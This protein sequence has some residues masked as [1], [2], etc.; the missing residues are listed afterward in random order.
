MFHDDRLIVLIPADPDTKALLYHSGQRRSGEVFTFD[1]YSKTL[2]Q[3]TRWV[4]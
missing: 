1:G 3:T 2:I 4:A